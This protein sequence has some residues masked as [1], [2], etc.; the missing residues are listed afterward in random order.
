MSNAVRLIAVFAWLCAVVPAQSTRVWVT[1][2]RLIES[3]KLTATDRRRIETQLLARLREQTKPRLDQEGFEK[4]LRECDE[5]ARDALRQL[6]FFKAQTEVQKFDTLRPS[7]VRNVRIDIAVDEGELYSMGKLQFTKSAILPE[8]ALRA[9]F[10]LKKGELFDTSQVRKGLE[11]LRAAYSEHG[12]INFMPFPDTFIDDQRHVVNLQI[13]LDEGRQYRIGRVYVFGFAP[14]IEKRVHAILKSGEVFA[15]R[16]M[17]QALAVT[18]THLS[19]TQV[20]MKRNDEQ[21]T[22]DFHIEHPDYQRKRFTPRNP[23]L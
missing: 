5:R 21:S 17:D 1:A 22:L 9:L 18:K 7:G 11:N 10:P 19:P 23:V 6:G 4:A 2:V 12:Y 8:E 16:L 14:A 15:P 20:M 13:D 3:K